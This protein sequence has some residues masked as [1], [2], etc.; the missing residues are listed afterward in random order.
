ML[1]MFT[2][3]T[4]KAVKNQN[5]KSHAFFIFF[6]V[7]SQSNPPIRIEINLTTL[8]STLK[9]HKSNTQIKT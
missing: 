9:R 2:L 1:T 3:S 6:I 8:Q 7:E 4:W 5:K